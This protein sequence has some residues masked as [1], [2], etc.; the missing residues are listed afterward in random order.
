MLYAGNEKQN[1][2]PV[3]PAVNMK[4][5]NK[6]TILVIDDS[7][8][9]VVLLEAIL[10]DHGYKID[11][12][13]NAKEAFQIISRQLP[14]LI[15]LDLLMPRINGYEFLES[16]KSKEATRNIPVVVISAVTDNENI[17]KTMK[18]GAHDYIKKP[19][20]IQNLVD[21]V[22]SILGN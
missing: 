7:T 1:Q 15:L 10:N 17:K 18:L 6:P 16:I 12:A 22:T 9:N 2:K 14:D 3:K 21:K 13:F 11:T 8:T 19:V 5:K 20:D 4:E